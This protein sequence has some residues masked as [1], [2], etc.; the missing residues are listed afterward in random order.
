M[1]NHI[2]FI[3]LKISLTPIRLYSFLFLI[4]FLVE[5]VNLQFN[6]CL[7]VPL[8]GEYFQQNDGQIVDL[9]R[10]IIT[11]NRNPFGHYEN[12]DLMEGELLQINEFLNKQFGSWV[13]ENPIALNQE[14]IL[15]VKKCIIET[16]NKSIDELIIRK[17]SDDPRITLIQ[18]FH[19]K[20]SFSK[21]TAL[22]SALD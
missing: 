8:G 9:F 5:L 17:D 15:L 4:Y 18:I 10:R 22:K 6:I 21:G 16:P 19:E 7:C 3:F 13:K 14:E 2:F 11:E 1:L 20:I 12:P